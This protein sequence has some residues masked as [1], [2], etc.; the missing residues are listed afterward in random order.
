MSQTHFG[1]ETVDEAE[2]AGK[3]QTLKFRS[4]LMPEARCGGRVRVRSERY[5]GVFRTRKVVH[6]LDT[7]GGPWYSDFESINDPGVAVA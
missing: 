2:K 5:N 7:M 4:L 3:P 6:D 1:F